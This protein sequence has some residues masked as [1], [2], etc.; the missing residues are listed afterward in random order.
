MGAEIRLQPVDSELLPDVMFVNI[1]STLTDVE[2]SSNLL[3]RSACSDQPY[4][5]HFSRR[6]RVGAE[7]FQKRRKHL[8]D[9]C[10]EDI[11]ESARLLVQPANLQPVQDG[12]NQALYI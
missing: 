3:G 7:P 9:I 2:G 4:D 6:K 5:L 11:K 12:D 1:N 10:F 8:P